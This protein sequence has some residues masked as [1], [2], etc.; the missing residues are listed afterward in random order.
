MI[1]ERPLSNSTMGA[2]WTS[3]WCN[4]CV[5]DHAMHVDPDDVDNGCEILLRLYVE[6]F[7]IEEL[8]QHPIS[9]AWGASNLTCSAF[10][11]CACDSPGLR[12]NR[13][14]RP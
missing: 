9:T 14:A 4:A 2:I 5:H 12:A 6:D 10:E 1:D 3:A 11:P 7:P 8:T 13:E